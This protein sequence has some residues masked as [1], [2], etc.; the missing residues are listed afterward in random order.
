[1]NFLLAL[2]RVPRD[3]MQFESGKRVPTSAALC[4]LSPLTLYLPC[5]LATIV[6]DNARTQRC[7]GQMPRL[8]TPLLHTPALLQLTLCSCA[9]FYCPSPFAV[10]FYF[11]SG[12]NF[13][14]QQ[15]AFFFNSPHTHT[16]TLTAMCCFLFRVCVCVLSGLASAL[17]RLLTSSICI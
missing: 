14:C 16:H 1:M 8:L 10:C 2:S 9:C 12:F 15:N 3:K 7:T 4:S 17:L 5:P 6:Y 11:R 13:R